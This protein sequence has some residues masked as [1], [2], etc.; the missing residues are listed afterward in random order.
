MGA[1]AAQVFLAVTNA[2]FHLAAVARNLAF[3]IYLWMY[4][5]W[6]FQVRLDGQDG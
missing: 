6:L 1:N 3:L 4:T 2:L 5:P